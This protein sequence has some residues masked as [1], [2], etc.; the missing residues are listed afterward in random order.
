MSAD[1]NVSTDAA[2]MKAMPERN[3]TRFR[4][5]SIASAAAAIALAGYA[6]VFFMY[7]NVIWNPGYYGQFGLL[8]DDDSH[9]VSEVIPGSPADRAGIKIGDRVERPQTL[10]DWFS[11]HPDW[12]TPLPGE[13][14]TL[15][16]FRGDKFHTLTLQARPLPPL[17][18]TNSARLVL[19]SLWLFVFV[20]VGLILV[21]LRPS[22]MTWGFYLFALNVVTV[23]GPPSSYLSHL[24]SSWLVIFHFFADVVAPAGV[25]GF[26]IFCVRFPANAAAGWRKVIESL[27]LCWFATAAASFTYTDVLPL[28][29]VPLDPVVVYMAAAIMW[30]IFVVGAAVLLTAYLSARGL[31]WHRVRW[32]VLGSACALAAAAAADVRL[33]GLVG[34]DPII[35]IFMLGPVAFLIT[36]F[37]AR[38]LERHRIKWIVL[39][40]I[41]AFVATVFDLVWAAPSLPH[42]A[43]WVAPFELLYIVLPLAVAY[44]IIRHRVI[45]V[46]FMASRALVLGVIASIVAVIIIAIDWLF[47]TRLPASRFQAAVYV[48][49][50][51]V[52]GFSLNATWRSIAKTIDFVF[53][54]PWYRTRE[55]AETIADATR[56]A[57]SKV[58][59]YEPLTAGIA[60]AFSLASAALF[61]RLED[62][63]FFRVAALGWPPGTTWHILP[64]DQLT[65]QM[66]KSQRIVDVDGFGWQKRNLPSEVAR[67]T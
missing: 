18:V 15:S 26:L 57:T 20:A 7:L 21:L 43:S 49:L 33:R 67:P 53:F 9:A 48:G 6:A 29:F 64:D 59:L 60:N 52:V 34:E 44:A 46:R 31:E 27:A 63:G 35:A 39:G 4:W 23:F 32:V 51:L 50:A 13:R 16:L 5:W 54:R 62:G 19:K 8:I 10:R 1:T 61:E 56:H 55:Q 38:G 65:V 3:A 17:S 11:L 30:A 42:R 36:Y 2:I 14:T 41:C 47:S 28:R 12:A 66:G 25:A 40:L 58:D 22:K 37:V 45:D 24:P